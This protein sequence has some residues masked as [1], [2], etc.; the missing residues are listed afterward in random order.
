[1]LTPFPLVDGEDRHSFLLVAQVGLG[2]VYPLPA[3]AEVVEGQ[4]EFVLLLPEQVGL[5]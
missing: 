1:M 4:L 3:Q 2:V 5:L